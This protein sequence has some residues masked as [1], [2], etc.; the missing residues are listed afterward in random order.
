MAHILIA[1]DDLAMRQFLATAL[2]RAGHVVRPCED[3]AAAF[4]VVGDLAQPV[5]L[6]LTDIV[7]P[8]MD[9][10]ELAQRAG[11]LRPGLPIVYITGFGLTVPSS[12]SN[13]PGTAQVLSKPVHLAHLLTEIERML[14]KLPP[15]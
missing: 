2:T 10:I 4:S 1:E 5:D 8:G 9:G 6:L 13:P 3:G 11:V 12:S 7:M 14:I 15:V